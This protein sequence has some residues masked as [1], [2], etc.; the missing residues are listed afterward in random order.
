[1]VEEKGEDCSG[2][3]RD[4]GGKRWLRKRGRIVVEVVEDDGGR[5]W[6]RKKGKDGSRGERW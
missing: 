1:M 3:G 4:D 2:G 6:L 5:W